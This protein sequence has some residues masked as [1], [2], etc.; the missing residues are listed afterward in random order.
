LK[1]QDIN[2]KMTDAWCKS[3]WEWGKP[4]TH[5]EYEKVPIVPIEELENGENV[6]DVAT[7]NKI[8]S[9]FRYPLIFINSLR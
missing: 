7:I 1:Y 5:E 2:A 3:G 6:Y 8:F 4:I 9:F